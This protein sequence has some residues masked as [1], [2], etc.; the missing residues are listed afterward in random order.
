VGKWEDSGDM[1]RSKY[2]NKKQIIDGYK[3]DSQAEASYY[4]RLKL[5]EKTG[6]ITMLEIHPKFPIEVN[7]EK[8]CT[9]IADFKY[10]DVRRGTIVADVK[11]M[12]TA[13]Y[14]LKKKLLRA[15]HG[16]DIEEVQ[17]KQ[18]YWRVPF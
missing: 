7:G 3:F 12:K 14:S 2:L 16:I 11:G 5:L 6:H 15:T 1:K 4:S 17:A 8:I 18:D 9:Y 13:L 10:N